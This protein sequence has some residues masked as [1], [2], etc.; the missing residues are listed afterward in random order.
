MRGLDWQEH[1]R[2]LCTSKSDM[3]GGRNEGRQRDECK[4]Y[5]RVELGIVRLV[6]WARNQGEGNGE[7]AGNASHWG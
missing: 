5:H 7:Q 3:D 4:Y 1:W 6:V 2:S